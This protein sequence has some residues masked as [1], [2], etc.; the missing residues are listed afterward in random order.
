M[1]ID[2]L[3]SF[4]VDEYNKEKKE[5]QSIAIRFSEKLDEKDKI[6]EDLKA[7]ISI[8]EIEKALDKK[9]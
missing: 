4:A 9:P 6:I 7:Q 8:Y 3:L 2:E 5:F 1:D